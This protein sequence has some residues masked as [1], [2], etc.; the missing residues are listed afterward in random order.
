MN[1]NSFLIKILNESVSVELKN[2]VVIYGI[3][4]KF[5]KSMNLY[6]KNVKKSLSKEKSIYLDSV[7]VRGSMIRYII[8]PSWI[9]IDLILIGKN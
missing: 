8:L 6:F 1:I 9:N 3:L 4:S 7:S 5:D 2:G